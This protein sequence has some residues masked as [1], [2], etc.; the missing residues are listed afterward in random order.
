MRSQ[1]FG[2]RLKPDR[3]Q[4]LISWLESLGEGERSFFIREALRKALLQENR[5]VTID[6]H[7]NEPFIEANHQTP[8]VF[9]EVS[10]ANE[11]TQSPDDLDSK[12]DNLANTF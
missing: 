1:R 9:L 2:F 11:K 3:D 4:E 5:M 12:L 6:L 8:K 10:A 7:R